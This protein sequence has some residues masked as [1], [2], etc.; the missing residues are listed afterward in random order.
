MTRALVD[1]SFYG[2]DVV[3]RILRKAMADANRDASC[4]LRGLSVSLSALL[5]LPAPPYRHVWQVV[6]EG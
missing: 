4:T 6:A 3:N 2:C 1:R 5:E